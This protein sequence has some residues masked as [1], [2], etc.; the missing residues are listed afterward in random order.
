MKN[1][2]EPGTK[3]IIRTK[4]T[5]TGTL[6]IDRKE[7][8]RYLAFLSKSFDTTREASTAIYYKVK[9]I[10]LLQIQYTSD[11]IAEN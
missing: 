11:R 9:G 10:K 8:Y 5:W 2:C 3:I 1:K 7:N 6:I 4:L